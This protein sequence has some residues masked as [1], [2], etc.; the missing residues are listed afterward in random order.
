MN[1]DFGNTMNVDLWSIGECIF[2]RG[3]IDEDSKI[4]NCLH[5]ICKDCA[6]KKRIDI[7]KINLCFIYLF[8]V[9]LDIR[10]F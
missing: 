2:C 6:V 1:S 3:K 8:F 5:I 7:G 10:Q 4:L 9:L